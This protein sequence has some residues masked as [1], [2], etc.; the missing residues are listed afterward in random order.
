MVPVSEAPA[1]A[2]CPNIQP[3]PAQPRAIAS[4]VRNGR[5]WPRKSR[6]NSAVINGPMARVTNTLATVVSVIAIMKAVYITPQH[7]LETQTGQ[8]A[9]TRLRQ[10]IGPRMAMSATSRAR[11]LNRL[12]QKF[13]SKLRAASRW[14]V[15]TPAML[16]I[17]VTRII[18]S[19]ARR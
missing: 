12:R 5:R 9:V 4:Q 2:S 6:A 7:T 10:N 3:I 8:R 19:T 16:H 17:R 14:R 13:T 11:A 15:T 18:R 1:V